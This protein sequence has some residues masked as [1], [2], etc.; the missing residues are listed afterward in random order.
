M[1]EKIKKKVVK[2]KPRKLKKFEL[3]PGEGTPPPAIPTEKQPKPKKMGTGDMLRRISLD[4]ASCIM[5][6]A[7]ALESAGCKQSTPQGLALTDEVIK[8]MELVEG[9]HMR[10]RVFISRLVDA[11]AIR[12]M[13]EKVDAPVKFDDEAWSR[14]YP[15]G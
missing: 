10:D 14:I 6:I 3:G 12:Y 15:K 11:P 13:A 9:V 2:K 8:T 1:P 4:V 5:P 7:A